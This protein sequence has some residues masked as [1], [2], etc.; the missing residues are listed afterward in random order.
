LNAVPRAF[1]IRWRSPRPE[2]AIERFGQLGIRGER[3]ARR[4]E[5]PSLTVEFTVSGA[6]EERHSADNRL[7]LVDRTRPREAGMAELRW[8]RPDVAAVGWATV[9]L[10]RAAA[11]FPGLQ[12]AAAADE[13]LLGGRA[14]LAAVTQGLSLA[15]LEPVTEGRLAASLA[16]HGEGPV[17]LYVRLLGGPTALDPGPYGAPVMSRIV[18]GPFGLEALLLGGPAFGPH[19]LVVGQAPI[20]ELVVRGERVPSS[21][22]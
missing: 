11:G 17:A 4:L 18:E 10:E 6:S 22:D 8:D 9:D 13:P 5:F 1:L 3:G 20:G 21:R 12:F 2:R 16:R 14:S 15:L 19:L 7:E